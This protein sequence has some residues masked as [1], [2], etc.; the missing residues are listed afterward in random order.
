MSQPCHTMGLVLRV[1][2]EKD[3]VLTLLTPEMGRI[4]VIA[5]G[6][7]SLKGPQMALS[8]PFCYADF[9]LYRRGELYW[10]NT[11]EIKECFPSLKTR[12]DALN[13]AAYFCEVA[14]AVSE[15]GE[16]SEELL[17]L[18]LNTL[19]FLS[20]EHADDELIKAVYEWRVLAMQGLAPSVRGCVGCG[21]TEDGDFALDIAQGELLC[22]ECRTR[23]GLLQER[24]VE[25][26]NAPRHAWSLLSPAALAV[27]R[28]TLSTPMEKM[29][30]FRLDDS[31]ALRDLSRAGE[32]FLRYHLDLD[33]TALKMYRQMK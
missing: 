4:T 16:P 33:S 29:L 31:I 26:D 22:L 17:R 23:R 15:A 9:E 30:S 12:L 5:K 24:T 3:V 21:K 1:K 28:F 2:R 32:Q 18:L 8:Q 20:K 7:R 27:L 13:L 25:D 11:G 10:L 6:A 14:A 19:Y